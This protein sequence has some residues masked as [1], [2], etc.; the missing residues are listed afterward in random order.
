MSGYIKLCSAAE[1]PPANTAREFTVQTAAGER[2]VCIANV[3][4]VISAM[5]NVCL[6]RGGPLGQGTIA[7]GKL[8][9]PWHG[10][11]FDPQTGAAVHNPAARVRVYPI[12][13]EGEDVFVELTN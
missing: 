2:V 7:D 5:D 4:G 13:V 3:D 6:H 12:K 8:I 9:C 11:Q 10:W 1:L